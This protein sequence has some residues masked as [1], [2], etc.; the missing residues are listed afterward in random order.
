MGRVEVRMVGARKREGQFEGSFLV[1]IVTVAMT[2]VHG[3]EVVDFRYNI[4][5]CSMQPYTASRFRRIYG[6]VR[7]TVITWAF[8]RSTSWRALRLLT[9]NS[10]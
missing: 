3:V 7:S 1:I 9:S 5:C 4:F 10:S 8:I 6:K 2:G